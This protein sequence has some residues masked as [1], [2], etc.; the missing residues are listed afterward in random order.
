MAAMERDYF[1]P[2]LADRESPE[3]WEE[4]GAPDLWSK[5]GDR[6]RQVLATHHPQYIE[7]DADGRIRD[8]F[9]ILLDWQ[10]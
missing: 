7:P 9:N 8:R 5:A 1:Y 2:G 6:A 3:V 4:N 10:I